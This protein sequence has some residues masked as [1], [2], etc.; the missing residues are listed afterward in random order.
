[1]FSRRVK[2]SRND[3]AVTRKHILN[4]ESIKHPPRF[5]TKNLNTTSK[6]FK[7]SHLENEET[8]STIIYCLSKSNSYPCL[9]ITRQKKKKCYRYIVES[10]H[11]SS[12]KPAF[13]I[14]EF[15]RSLQHFYIR[16][17]LLTESSICHITSIMTFYEKRLAIFTFLFIFI[18]WSYILFTS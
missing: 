4:I 15:Q 13:T 14:L 2:R 5:S 12:F 6:H 17:D 1:M 10:H 7:S 18:S 16:I 8:H 3:I 11:L 9:D